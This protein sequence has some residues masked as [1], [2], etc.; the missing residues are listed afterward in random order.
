MKNIRHSSLINICK[1]LPFV[2][3]ITRFDSTKLYWNYFDGTPYANVFINLLE[4]KA[5]VYLLEED[6]SKEMTIVELI[7]DL[8][9]WGKNYRDCL[10]EENPENYIAPQFLPVH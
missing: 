6:K 8:I 1:S 10:L 2:R 3:L 7:E 9:G 4:G 5:L